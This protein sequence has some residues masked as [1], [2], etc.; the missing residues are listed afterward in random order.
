MSDCSE[1]KNPL[2]H[3]GTSQSQ[4]LLTGM[5]KNNYA[6]ADEKDYADWIVFAS[7]FSGYLNY[8]DLENKPATDWKAFF[9]N[10]ISAQIGL[11]AVQNI[12]HYRHEVKE[13]FEFIRDDENKTAVE[14]IKLKFNE[15]FSAIFTLSKAFDLSRERLPDNAVLKTSLLNLIQVKL[16]PALKN[17]ISYYIAAKNKGYLNTSAM[18]DWKILNLNIHDAGGIIYETGLSSIWLNNTDR[19][20][21]G[22]YV[23]SIPEDDSIFNHPVTGY[24]KFY[25]SAEHAA[26]HN[27]FTGIFDTYLSVF[28]R[29]I[30][31][32]EKELTGTLGNYNLHTPHYALFLSFLKLFKTARNH[33]NTITQR[34]LDFYYREVLKL[35]PHAA[36][37]NKVHILTELTKQTDNYLLPAGTALKAGKDSLKKDV[38]Y[39]ADADSVINKA[40]ATSFKS[41]YIGNSADSVYYPGTTNIRQNN[42]GRI[43]ASPVANSADGLGAE[44]TSEN[45]EWQPFVSKV[46]K[47]AVLDSIAMTMAQIGFAVAS[48]YLYLTE[49]ERKVYLRLIT[50]PHG[51]LDGKRIECWLTTEK[52]WY[53]V[54][55]PVISSASRYFSDGMTPCTEISFTIPGSVPAICNYNAGVHGGN[56]GCTLPVLKIYLINDDSSVFEYDILKNTI[57]TK[58][59]VRVEVGM[60]STYNQKGLKN[61]V[62]S[63]DSGPVDASK[64]FLPFGSQPKKDAGFIIGHKEIFSKKNTTIRLNVEWAE[65][66]SSESSIKYET[67]NDENTSKPSVKLQFEGEGIWKSHSD[68]SG[69]ASDVEIFNGL[70]S[71]LQVLTSG[72]KIPDMAIFGYQDDYT[73]HGSSTVNGFMRLSL[74]SS[75]GHSKY[76]SDLSLYYAEKNLPAAQQSIKIKPTEPYTPK[77]K[78]LYAGYS[79]CSVTNLTSKSG[80]SGREVRFYHIYPFGE[81]EQHAQLNQSSEVYLLP[82]FS[83]SEAGI[84]VSHAGEFFI[85]IEALEPGGSV[86]MLFQ[87]LEGTSDPTVIKPENHI[88]WS[89][90][91]NNQW[92]DFKK[93]E[94]SDSTLDLVQSGIIS[95]AIPRQA[96]TEN[97]ILPS[98]QIWI[99][100]AVTK[101]AEA[102]CKLLSVSTQASVATFSDQDNAGDFLDNPLGAGTISKLKNPDAAV[103]KITQPYPS[104]GGRQNENDEHFYIRVSERL[105]H[106]ARG[107]T[108]WDYEHLVLEAF[109]EIYKVKCLNHTHIGN[110]VYNELKPGHVSIITI[111]MLQ[112]RNDT[113]PLKPYTQQSTLTRIEKF[114]SNRISC[115]VNLHTGQPQF[116]EVRLEFSLK[117]QEAYKDFKFYSDLLKE[118][119]T[120]F[121]SPWA[122]GDPN[123]ID[124]GGK[125][126]KSVLINFIEERYYVDFITDV[127]MYVKTD[128]KTAESSDRDVITASTAR[129]ILVSA[130]ATK[131]VIHPI[132]GSY[133]KPAAPCKENK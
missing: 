3:N 88:L 89:F 86:S 51:V 18:S 55:S 127:Y 10:D 52:E 60:G 16:A 38:F 56:F 124:F 87:V 93:E 96:T 133:K 65:I 84:P 108:V 118:E 4:R 111:P 77:I 17:L 47:D 68:D 130:T 2:Q 23:S 46:Y 99:R 21:W 128:D 75:F 91:G 100:A 63:N 29:I 76:L 117:L 11:I 121:L 64:P 73:I 44:L 101:A 28:T 131:H 32:A 39:T 27:L 113:N 95:F 123:S 50:N 107:I 36:E 31:E 129:S 25:P 67:N 54:D 41:V 45:K 81:G 92:I 122:F 132:T 97:S 112:N 90:L 106:K 1:H 35:Q 66:P 26:N 126:Y 19:L 48:H 59:E 114:L 104:F 80:F 105:R 78:S 85:G 20:T 62:L 5:D 42:S 115:F 22:E 61:L 79:A 70:L 13:R 119:I 7:E 6:L 58:T 74:K 98:G 24:T 71:K 69:I 15:L 9:S 116:E 103:K 72:Q 14:T 82:Q 120:R 110:G 8:Y 94:F 102:V 37:A 49:G 12:K 53:K 109:P 34:H 43:F 33:I 40:K 83:S 30:S 57:V 125:V